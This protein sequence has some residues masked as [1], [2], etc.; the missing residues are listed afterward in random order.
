MKEIL[1][2]LAKA[3]GTAFKLLTLTA[4]ASVLA[5]AS[6]LFVMLVLGRYV[7]YGIDATLYTL[8]CGLL[9]ALAM[10]YAFR[11]LRLSLART[12]NSREDTQLAVGAF[13]L[14][15]TCPISELEKLPQSA[16][17][18]LTR[19]LDQVAAAFNPANLCAVLDLPFALLF[20]MVLYLLHPVLGVVATCFIL[21]IV[22]LR[23]ASRLMQA[24]KQAEQE[25]HALT[26]N[27]LFGNAMNSADTVRMFDPAGWLVGTWARAFSRLGR[28][29]ADLNVANGAVETSVASLQILQGAVIIA[30]GATYVVSG[31]LNVSALIGANILA[32]RALA[33][34]SRFVQMAPSLNRA[35]GSLQEL[36]GIAEVKTVA[37]TNLPSARPSGQIEFRDVSFTFPGR[38]TA[39]FDRLN[40]HLPAGGIL[41]VKGANGTGKTTFIRLLTGLLQ[42]GHGQILSGGIDIGQ[43]Q[44]GY[45][46]QQVSYLP[47]EPNFF[48][49]S[50]AENIKTANPELDQAGIHSLLEQ[51]GLKRFIEENPEGS[52]MQL[53]AGGRNLAL[54]I[55]K[56]LAL[57]RALATGANIVVLDDPT[58]GLDADGRATIREAMNRFSRKRLTTIVATDDPEIIKRANAI[59]DLDQRPPTFA[60]HAV[61]A[62]APTA[63]RTAGRP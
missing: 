56:R 60:I 55:R 62:V 24:K 54:G 39:L 40:L 50:I 47:Q 10:E 13:G 9:L 7:S 19:K 22:P 27:A 49:A 2:R 8:F 17:V 37:G 23:F 59:L 21:S 29:R 5:L 36:R 43:L 16:R 41:L 32:A 31:D 44:A 33:P 28:I 52:D 15:A 42:P 48:D 61:K 12:L 35:A 46:R 25:N 6:P 57:A 45:W 26:T 51:A 34:V 1:A 38:P 14:L 30:V 53:R 58:E 11:R 18:Q 63:E 20:L 3:P 4:L